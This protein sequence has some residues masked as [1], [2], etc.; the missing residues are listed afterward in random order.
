MTQ[1]RSVQRTE[2]RSCKCIGLN[3]R[4]ASERD[5]SRDI[6]SLDDS[7]AYME[8]IL[9]SRVYEAAIETP[10]HRSDRL[11][12]KLACNIYLKREDKQPVF[13]FKIRGAYNMIS[14]LSAEEL[15]RGIIT[16]SAGNHAQG[17]AFSASKLG[18]D[19]VVVMPV[20][21]PSIKI[22][23]VRRLGGTVDLAGEN[24][25]QCQ[26]YAL[27]RASRENRVY[28]PPFDNHLV[29]AGQ[30]TCGMEIMRQWGDSSHLPH[31]IFIP[32]GGGG[33]ISG[34]GVYIKRL[35]PSIKVIGVE[36][37]G[38]NALERSLALGKIVVLDTVDG[39]A[40]GVAVKRV[41]EECFRLCK[42][43]VDDVITV[44][45]DE[46]CSAIKDVFE[47][48]RSIL[49]PAGALSVA[50]A[51]RYIRDSGLLNC[52]IVCITTGANINF[53]RLR[54]VS[55]RADIGSRTEALLATKIRET[56]GS[57]L[58]FC[59]ALSSCGIK[60]DRGGGERGRQIT[61]FKY[62]FSD[63]SEAL[64]FYSVE[65]KDKED[66]VKLSD[67]LF[68]KHGL[69]TFDISDDLIA[70][71]HIRYLVGGPSHVLHERIYRI[72]FPERQGAL[73]LFLDAIGGEFN[74]SLFHYRNT[75]MAMGCVL[76]GIQV[77]P[78]HEKEFRSR[79]DSLTYPYVEV[80][81]SKTLEL[82]LKKLSPIK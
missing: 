58:N 29:I 39:F 31:A 15:R 66:G 19:A 12:A 69:E 48:T 46:I 8:M 9:R 40:D 49:E 42:G 71:E 37:V 76:V 27:E 52:H 64:V 67:E 33:L 68:R 18:C 17:V 51:K 56:P 45:N 50:G 13:S 25:D 24:Y 60:R 26:T 36:P 41:G 55:E 11:S 43:L 35:F 65:V 82:F 80:T 30:G 78:L 75:G 81:G 16:S 53:E 77:P 57:F 34:V 10:L 79:M 70:K 3:S 7:T 2:F 6:F 21:T 32:V 72:E 23:N 44:T 38:A 63:S 14:N 54:V 74:I 22:E 62:R 1:H 28:I 5:P 4:N 73:L 59:N 20:T 47:D 61:E